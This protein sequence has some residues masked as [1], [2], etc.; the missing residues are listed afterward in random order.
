MH[1]PIINN[2]CLS[3]TYSW[4][5]GISKIA[6]AFI[7]LE[8]FGRRFGDPHDQ[9]FSENG[10]D[11]AG[12]VHAIWHIDTPRGIVQI[13]DYWWNPENQLSI[14]AATKKAALWVISW[15]KIHGI[16]ACLGNGK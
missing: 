13:S 5:T 12:R 11:G 16:K 10:I 8:T 4:H 3:D 15:L 9:D 6:T 1:K 2:V 14:R 7:D